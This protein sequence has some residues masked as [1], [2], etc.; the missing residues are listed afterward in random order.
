MLSFG[1]D[2]S[3]AFCDRVRERDVGV[4]IRPAVARRDDDRA[5]E[6]REELAALRV[7]GALLVLDG[8]PLAMPG[9][10]LLPNERRG[11]ARARACRRS[12]P[13]GTRRRG[14]ARRG[15]APA[16]PSS[17]AS[18]STSGPA[19][20]TRGA[21]MKTPRS[22]SVLAHELEI[23]LEAREL[24]PVARFGAT[25][26]CVGERRAVDASRRG[27][28]SR[29][30]SRGSAAS[31]R[32][33]ALLEPVEPDEPPIAVDSPPGMTSPSSSA[34][35]SGFRTS[36]TC[37]PSRRSIA[38]C[39]RKF[40]WTARTPIRSFIARETLPPRASTPFPPG[41]FGRRAPGCS[42]YT[43]KSARVVRGI[44]ADFRDYQ[45]RVS[46]SS[47]GASAAASR[48]R[49]GSPRP[50]GDARQHLRVAEVRGRLD[51]RLCPSRTGR[52]S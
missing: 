46:S 17:S 9:H 22:G 2:A 13:G 29:R 15:R 43:R 39:S 25:G 45:P 49:I 19:S 23:G 33:I 52:R 51:D 14:C 31:K 34:S 3:R 41:A 20:R 16:S 37:A 35:C 44:R 6:L 7:G 10:A 38:A 1:I 28:S 21:R 18:T 42:A 36:T 8:R 26:R 5:R 48:P 24:A 47:S 30:T 50:V 4:R 40:P 11:T 12:A 32:R 27:G